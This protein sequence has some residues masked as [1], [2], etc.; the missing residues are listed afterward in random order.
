MGFL[1][2]LQNSESVKN[3][4]NMFSRK[5]SDSFDSI[6][7]ENI[8]VS[9]IYDGNAISEE[10]NALQD[11]LEL[12]EGNQN[13]NVANNNEQEAG[14]NA[15]QAPATANTFSD[16]FKSLDT[17]KKGGKRKTSSSEYQNVLSN[18]K[19]LINFTKSPFSNDFSKNYKLLT[20]MLSAHTILKSHCDAYLNKKTSFTL[21]GRHRKAVVK[22]LSKMLVT[23][24][25]GITGTMERVGSMPLEKQSSLTWETVFKESRTKKITVKDISKVDK[26]GGAASTVLKINSDNSNDISGFFKESEIL[27]NYRDSINDSIGSIQKK[28]DVQQSLAQTIESFPLSNKLYKKVSVCEDPMELETLLSREIDDIDV[29]EKKTLTKFQKKWFAV[30]TSSTAAKG[31]LRSAG[32]IIDKG[33]NYK[34]RE[35]NV[36]TSRIANLLGLQS[37]VVNSELAELSYE[38]NGETK[39]KEGL[40]MSTAEG[41]EA[42]KIKD[43]RN[44]KNKDDNGFNLGDVTGNF[45]REMSNLDIL[46]YVCGQID[47]HTGNFFVKKDENGKFNGVV[48]IDN[49][50]SFGKSNTLKGDDEE[51]YDKHRYGGA[52]DKSHAKAV[53]SQGKLAQ[54]HIDAELAERVL[55]I[56]KDMI[57]YTLMDLIEPQFVEACWLRLQQLQKAILDAK[58]NTP[59]KLIKP[60]GWG[61]ETHDASAKRVDGIK[62]ID[63]YSIV[64]AYSMFMS[65][66]INNSNIDSYKVASSS[67]E[68]KKFD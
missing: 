39:T 17:S 29:T 57:T 21:A 44:S 49:D 14:E 63:A 65:S 52:S 33:A 20:T 10:E 66:N 3:F 45:Q 6:P 16:I 67:E 38:E 22:T 55:T 7:Q 30:Y 40:L 9:S 31:N 47:R 37:L 25:A 61:A 32:V 50:F 1:D 5:K 35:R 26:F 58:S 46:D 43:E 11:A 28:L 27:T 59:D 68:A 54:P 4:K 15:I 34:L 41:T 60:D 53:V 19:L 12:N 36:A 51:S 64:T 8:K 24:I 62:F 13:L 56:N 48:G 42:K 18:L 23:D 2:K